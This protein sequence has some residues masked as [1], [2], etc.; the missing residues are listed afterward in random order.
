MDSRGILGRDRYCKR[1]LRESLKGVYKDSKRQTQK[2]VSKG[3]QW[4]VRI[5]GVSRCSRL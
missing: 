4:F 5:V 2:G 3:F 1:Y